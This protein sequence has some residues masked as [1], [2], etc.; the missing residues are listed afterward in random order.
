MRRVG[1]LLSGIGDAGARADLHVARCERTFGTLQPSGR[2]HRTD[3]RRSTGRVGASAPPRH[4]EAR[5][6]IRRAHR[7]A[8]A[9][10][11][12]QNRSGPCGRAGRV[13]VQSVREID[14][15]RSW[16]D[17]ADAG[18]DPAVRRHGSVQPC[19]EHSGWR[20]VPA[21]TA[22]SVRQRRATRARGVQ[23]GPRSSGQAR[24]EHPP[25]PRDPALR[26]SHQRPRGG[27]AHAA[28]AIA[29]STNQPI[30]SM[31]AR[32]PGSR[33]PNPRPAP[34]RWS[35]DRPLIPVRPP[36]DRRGRRPHPASR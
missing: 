13:G 24:A 12:S 14:Q 1:G 17:A 27:A 9:P 33:T 23:R 31:A 22:R 30:S 36:R 35:V 8:R 26:R 2:R 3:V 5:R 34:T 25:L 4:A 28:G 15:G 16:L 18:N 21:P 11:R 32:C 7:R 19:P 6:R 20:G 10:E 29:R